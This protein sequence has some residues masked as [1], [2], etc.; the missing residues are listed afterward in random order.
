MAKRADTFYLLRIL[1]Q[2]E[3]IQK[4]R[5]LFIGKF[6]LGLYGLQ[7]GAEMSSFLLYVH[8]CADQSDFC[9]MPT[10]AAEALQS[11]QTDKHSR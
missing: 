6:G 7:I 2:S 4:T 10:F 9:T 11:Q 1:H 5:L 3:A 8:S